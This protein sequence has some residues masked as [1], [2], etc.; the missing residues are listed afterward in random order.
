MPPVFNPIYTENESLNRIQKRVEELTQE[1][2]SQFLSLENNIKELY[3]LKGIPSGGNKGQI[4]V[5]RSASDYDMEWK[6]A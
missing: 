4:L 3:R 5:K 2:D 1:I 6:D